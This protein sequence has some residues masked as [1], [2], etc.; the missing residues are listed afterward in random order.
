ALHRSEA[1]C[2]APLYALELSDRVGQARLAWIGKIDLVRI[3]ADHHPASPS[4]TGQEHLHLQWRGVLGLVEDDEGIVEGPPPHEGQRRD[5]DLARSDA[6]LDLLG[7]NHVV[8]AIV[9][10]T[11]VGVDFFLHVSRK[12]AQPLARFDRGPRKDQAIDA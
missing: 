4:E 11:Q 3:A 5:F 6:P 2:R 9:K 7:R 8:E 10:G 12:E 1:Y